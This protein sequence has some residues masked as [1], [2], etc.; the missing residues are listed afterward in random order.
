MIPSNQQNQV[1][2]Q[3][4]QGNRRWVNEVTVR[5]PQFF[6]KLGAQCSPKYL[7][8]GCSDNR[9]PANELL[10]LLPGELFVHRNIANIVT[11]T[12]LNCLSVL[13]FAVDILKVEHLIICGHYG[14]AGIQTVLTKQRIGLA[15][16]WLQHV[17]NVYEKYI[18]YFHHRMLDTTKHNRLCELNVLEQVINMSRTTIVIDAW[19]RNQKLNIYS[20]IYGINDGLLHALL[21]TLNNMEECNMHYKTFLSKYLNKF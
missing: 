14:C 20:L 8:I 10:G 13:Q 11:H 18:D 12:D 3:L 17:Q 5:D 21:P 4:L 9:V 6:K 19:K 16:N 15:D 2:L 7:W 1:Q